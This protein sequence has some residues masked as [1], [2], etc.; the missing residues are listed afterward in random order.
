MRSTGF[1]LAWL[2][3]IDIDGMVTSLGFQ[4][5]IALRI[6]S[7]GVGSNLSSIES[8]DVFGDGIWRFDLEVDIVDTNFVVEP[9]DFLSDMVFRNPASLC[10]GFLD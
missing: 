10:D 7:P 9:V 2:T 6:L 8:N 3:D 1:V 4:S 5:Y